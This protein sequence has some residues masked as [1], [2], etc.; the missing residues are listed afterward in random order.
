MKY[1]SF[2]KSLVLSFYLI[3]IAGC[4]N[5][6]FGQDNFTCETA[7]PFMFD[8]NTTTC[9]YHEMSYDY[10]TNAPETNIQG[11]C[12][13]NLPSREV[14]WFKFTAAFEQYNLHSKKLKFFQFFT[15]EC[16][17]LTEVSC[18]KGN[19]I[20]DLNIGQEYFVK[21][22][23][24]N[25]FRF[26]V[27]CVEPFGKSCSTAGP[28]PTD[29]LLLGCDNADNFIEI[30]K[31][32]Y[33]EPSYIKPSCGYT[34]NFLSERWFEFDAVAT[35]MD[36]KTQSPFVGMA[37]YKKGNN[38]NGLEEL[39][40]FFNAN[41]E[42]QL[43]TAYITDL[44]VGDKYFMQLFAI[45]NRV[46]PYKICLSAGEEPLIND[47]CEDAIPYPYNISK[48]DECEEI[49]LDL[50]QAKD[51]SA[52]PICDN[53]TNSSV[54][55]SFEATTS[56]YYFE[57]LDKS[58]SIAIYQNCDHFYVYNDFSNFTQTCLDDVSGDISDLIVGN[59]Y[60][61]RIWNDFP[62]Q[63]SFCLREKNPPLDNDVCETA[64]PLEDIVDLT[65]SC[66]D[67]AF[68]VEMD[69]SSRESGSRPSCANRTVYSRWYSF[70]VPD[71]SIKIKMQGNSD[72]GYTIYKNNNCDDLTE[73]SCA[74]GIAEFF[75]C[76]LESGQEYL[77]QVWSNV[78]ENSIEL[79]VEEKTMVIPDEC[80]TAITFNNIQPNGF[81]F[82]NLQS[83]NNFSLLD[84]S[85][86]SASCENLPS[87]MNEEQYLGH[88]LTF[89]ATS[90]AIEVIQYTGSTYMDYAVFESGSCDNL[91]EVDCVSG[92]S[93]TLSNLVVGTKYL[94]LIYT[95]EETALLNGVRICVQESLPELPNDI[96]S[97]AIPLAPFGG[98][99]LNCDQLYS[100][101]NTQ[102][103]IETFD[104]CDQNAIGQW[105]TFTPASSQ[106]EFNQYTP[107]TFISI[108]EAC[109]EDAIEC[110][111]S[112]NNVILSLDVTKTYLMHV[113]N[114]NTSND[115][116]FCFSP[117]ETIECESDYAV[118]QMYLTTD[119]YGDEI[120][121]N[122][123]YQDTEEY[124][125]SVPTNTYQSNSSY[126]EEVCVDLSRCV[127]FQIFDT[128]GDGIC[129]FY[130][131]GSYE[132]YLNG[133][134]FASGGDYRSGTS[135]TLNCTNEIPTIIRCA[136]IQQVYEGFYSSNENFMIYHFEAERTGKYLFSTCSDN[137]TCPVR[138]VAYN[139][140]DIDRS[141]LYI[142]VSDVNYCIDQYGDEQIFDF[143]AGNSYTI[144]IKN[145]FDDCVNPSF[146]LQ[147]SYLAPELSAVNCNSVLENKPLIRDGALYGITD[148]PMDGS[149]IY[150]W[151]NEQ[152]QK[153][154][155][156]KGNPYFSPPT[157]GEYIL[158]VTH[159]DFPGCEQTFGPRII[160]NVN[161]CCELE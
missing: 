101:P 29:N 20:V 90:E 136:D 72:A 125:V 99:G 78:K 94:L 105:F 142:Y 46:I 121:W 76:T 40:C 60:L 37:I 149:E 152:G 65:G 7:A 17:N 108:Y 155:C 95:N 39:L 75:T 4:T 116:E 129:C 9:D 79:C 56:N 61:M 146:N 28:F 32:R 148:F 1:L 124:I 6:V 19:T 53:V 120:S 147:I 41:L 92:E 52:F 140:C 2:T 144:I 5:L 55:Y 13:N 27:F 54:W 143:V 70:T 80:S 23:R 88:W 81:C 159:P 113:W 21:I 134:L 97:N 44:V 85:N 141:L 93:N 24:N 127:D 34:T 31:D 128:F 43:N 67:N 26:Q 66:N 96:C 119:N 73:V 57:S 51:E 36:I 118:F 22:I 123:Q 69:S 111:S 86:F 84:N 157:T 102:A 47:K 117:F 154:A 103:H 158:V 107:N 156:F 104:D 38:C 8:I 59:T 109:G 138:L 62:N 64:S 153:V 83:S 114:K 50:R 58:P 139:G 100:I 112:S 45:A 161:G 150:S 48:Y 110:M 74:T 18:S 115:I 16:G 35:T 132:L 63:V 11:S 106:M 82:E 131:I 126:Y 130:G 133:T 160:D 15:G 151:Y 137:N 3:L 77:M 122:L 49:E 89:T 33:E 14:R 42:G 135:E 145:T 91:V 68:I 10:F 98:E 87:C 30:D 71:N 25:S 12:F